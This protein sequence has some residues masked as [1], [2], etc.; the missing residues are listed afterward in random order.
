MPELDVGDGLIFPS[1]G[2]SAST[3]SSTFNSLLPTAICCALEAELRCPDGEN[4][5]G[6]LR[7]SHQDLCLARR[8][9]LSSVVPD[10]RNTLLPQRPPAKPK[11]PTVAAPLGLAHSSPPPGSS[12]T[13][14]CARPWGQNQAAPWPQLTL[15]PSARPPLGSVRDCCPVSFSDVHPFPTSFSVPQR[16]G[17]RVASLS[18]LGLGL[19]VGRGL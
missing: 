12:A 1:T 3:M 5:G 8:I 11:V 7:G 10:P 15:G 14:S 13:L 2:A 9:W 17:P 18:K 6:A 4:R 16:L 19:R